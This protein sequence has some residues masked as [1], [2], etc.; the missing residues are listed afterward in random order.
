MEINYI[1][2]LEIQFQGQNNIKFL[3]IMKKFIKLPQKKKLIS[4]AHI[5]YKF[6]FVLSFWIQ[7]KPH[8]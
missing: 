7:L 6:K 4:K 1:Q 5:L 8:S 3:A 2:D